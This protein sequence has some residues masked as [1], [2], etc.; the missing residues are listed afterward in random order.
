M[1]NLHARHRI[2]IGL[3]QF[4]YALSAC[5]WARD[6]QRLSARLVGGWSPSGNGIACRS[7]RSGFHLLLDALDLTAGDEILVSAITHPDMVRII[8]AH[9][10]VPV[11]VD[12]EI[13]TLAPRLDLAERLVTRKT[14]AILVAHLFGGR[15]DMG[16]TV[17]FARRHRLLLWEDCAQA[18]TG[19]GDTGDPS[20]D[21][22]MYSFGALKT[23]TALGGA[24]IKVRDRS[25]LQR[26]RDAQRSWPVQSRRRYTATVFK[27]FAFSLVTRPPAYGA[28]AWFLRATGRDF[29]KI[30]NS[31]VR[32]FRPGRLVPQ[33]EVQPSAPL[34]ATMSYRLLAFD[35]LRLRRRAESGEWLTAHLPPGVRLPG[36][37]MAGHTHWLFPVLSSEPDKL[38]AA[39]RLAGFDAARGASSVAPVAAPAGRPEAEPEG[40]RRMM[41][42]LVFLPAYPELSPRSLARLAAALDLAATVPHRQAAHGGLR[43]A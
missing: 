14:R 18:F 3:R 7:V 21:A 39:C 22:S 34:L 40:A 38:I 10:L 11:P 19:A 24:L 15:F 26:M 16:A 23:G 42:N 27:F 13:G 8:E 1:L 29:D 4:L 33:L 12:L 32:A 17:A 20:A 9:G 5:I 43:R 35:G 41:Q 28:L 25:V 6:A 37:D 36:A 31:S 2:D 30:V